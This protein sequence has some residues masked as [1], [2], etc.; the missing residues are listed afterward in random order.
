[1]SRLIF[2]GHDLSE[3]FD[4][5]EP[6]IT[7]LKS[8]PDLRDVPGRDGSVFAGSRLGASVVTFQISI[9]GD[10]SYRRNAFSTLGMW[11]AVD[12]P[13]KLVLPDTPDLYYMAVPNDSLSLNRAIG[14]EVTKV[15]FTLVDPIAYG[16]EVTVTVPSSGSVTF[17]VGGTYKASPVITAS[18]AVRSG[19]SLVW[20]LLLDSHD[21]LR[22]VTGSSSSR[23]I[24]L[25][26]SSRT[27]TLAGAVTLPTLT[28]DW[29]ELEPGVHT[30][31][32]DQGSGSSTVK[33]I[34]RW[35]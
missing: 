25:D 32:N 28:S 9:E 11:L 15:S 21:H 5:G 18:S 10:A 2:N 27:C 30:I 20:G 7:I 35:L 24:V 19:S 16:R 1:M 22:V 17:N 4:V 8:T 14:A 33:Y 23:A 34:E 6:E 29:F 3:M 12:E 31:Q 26:C 13:K